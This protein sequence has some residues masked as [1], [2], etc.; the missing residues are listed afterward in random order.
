MNADCRVFC[1]YAYPVH[2]VRRQRNRHETY[3][4]DA[5]TIRC[6]YLLHIMMSDKPLVIAV[7]FFGLAL[8]LA[9][10]ISFVTD[11]RFWGLCTYPAAW[12]IMIVFMMIRHWRGSRKD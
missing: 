10:V 12:V 6:G 2:Y 4:F 11:S 7:S 8:I 5:E 9:H 3:L 1:S